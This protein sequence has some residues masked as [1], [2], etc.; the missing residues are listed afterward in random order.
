MSSPTS[1]NHA[2]SRTTLLIVRDRPSAG[3]GIY[4]YYQA[5]GKYQGTA[6]QYT[7]VGRSYSFYGTHG[8]KK[9][10]S[11]PARLFF[12]S[13]AL[14]TKILK[15]R[16]KVVLVNP[17]MDPPSFRSLRRDALNVLIGRMFGR[18]VVVFWRG[19]DVSAV[20]LPEFPGGN[21]SLLARIYKMAA[22]H[23]V[24]GE[25]FKADLLRWEFDS[26]IHVETTVVPDECL[27]ATPEPLGPEKLRTNL[28]YLSRVEIAKGVFELLEAYQILKQKNPA[29]TLTI[30]GDGP[31]LEAL[32]ARA[33][34]MGLADISFPGY[35]S[36]AA[37]VEAYRRGGVFCFL[38]Y[39]EGM[40]NAV[41]EALAMGLP[42]VSSD[43]G[44]LQ[45]IL[46]DGENGFVLL[47]QHDAPLKK[48]FDP[49]AVAN[50]IERLVET[51]ELHERIST[52]NW[53]Y[54]RQRF[55]AP[56]VARRLDA[57]CLGALST[58]TARSQNPSKAATPIGVK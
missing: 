51:P 24:L 48:K 20:G 57:I 10:S 9:V 56:V 5:I 4:N 1:Q 53:R 7:D 19:W 55:A 27:A 12:D 42:V 39:T 46:R 50:A 37:K 49:I 28:L 47:P 2:G 29:Y 16:P 38:S 34:E 33:Q 52:I 41:L 31:D 36:G 43:A 40:P 15:V 18:K 17:S 44:G 14:F 45:D 25:R 3:G 22:S 26:P 13:L 32:K 21:K 6:P 8:D 58:E 35:L 23:I 11:T 30:A 54:A